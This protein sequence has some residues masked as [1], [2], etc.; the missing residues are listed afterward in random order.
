M[1]RLEQEN[2]SSSTSPQS[3][4]SNGSP[5]KRFLERVPKGMLAIPAI[6]L[7]GIIG[8]SLLILIRQEPPRAQP[9]KVALPV[10]AITAR[11]VD[12]TVS[13]TGYGTVSAKRDLEVRPEV[14]G[15]IV[16]L[17]PAME[18]GGRVSEGDTLFQIDPRDYEIALE[19]EKAN[20]ERARYELKLEQGNQIVAQR[21]WKLLDKELAQNPLGKELALRKPQLQEKEAAF[22]A[23]QSRVDKARLDLDRTLVKAPFS[24]VVLEES[25]EVGRYVSPSSAVARLASTDEF[26]VTVQIPQDE[27]PSLGF[28]PAGAPTIADRSAKIIQRFGAKGESERDGRVVRL[29]GDVDERGRMAQL[30]VSVRSPLDPPRGEVPLLLGT[31]VGVQLSGE[32]VEDV[33]RLPR[34]AVREGDVIYLIGSDNHLRT[35]AVEK[36][37][38]HLDDVFVRGDVR[39]GD[40]VVTSQLRDALEGSLLRITRLDENL[41]PESG[42]NS[43]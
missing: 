31:Y 20:L 4:F 25:L 13:T 6:L 7:V 12:A 8:A 11:L 40:R 18:I 26:Y 22:A 3:G 21:E 42:E 1:E 32:T 5:W 24:G 33:I 35:V 30:I 39:D 34:Y 17:L 27:L 16:E 28:T 37:F 41:L 10:T 15:H 14:S 36:I 38:S 9:E 2:H 29:L 23:A 19:T 43:K